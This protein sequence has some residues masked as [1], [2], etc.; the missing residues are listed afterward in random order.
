MRA[1]SNDVLQE[2]QGSTQLECEKFLTRRSKLGFVVL[3]Q[4]QR[5]ALYFHLILSLS[6]SWCLNLLH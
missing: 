1:G 4:E 3:N 5:Q 6:A 2:R